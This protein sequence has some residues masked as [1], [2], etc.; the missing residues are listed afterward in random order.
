M[1]LLSTNADLH[2]DL[3]LSCDSPE[4]ARLQSEAF[5]LVFLWPVGM[6]L[7]YMVLLVWSRKPLPSGSRSALWSAIDFLH[8][9]YRTRVLDDFSLF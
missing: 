5:A 4:Y 9:D 3:S 2:E 1:R 8:V 7:L 6:P